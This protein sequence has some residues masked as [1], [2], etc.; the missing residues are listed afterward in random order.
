MWLRCVAEGFTLPQAKH[1]GYLDVGKGIVEGPR[2]KG[3]GL[4]ALPLLLNDS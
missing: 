2:V 4:Q 3:E 1:D